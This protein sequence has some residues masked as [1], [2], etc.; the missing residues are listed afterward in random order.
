MKKFAFSAFLL[1]FLCFSFTVS[2]QT[3]S[4]WRGIHRDGIYNETQLSTSWP[5]SGPARMWF[6]E[7]IGDGYGSPVIAN[8]K[9][10]VNG[11]IDSISHVFAFDLKGQL[12]WK[13]ANGKEFTGNGFSNKFAGSRSTPTVVGDL[14]YACSGTGRVACYDANTGK[15]RWGVNVME[16]FN[17]KMNVFGFSESMLIDGDK[18]FCFPGGAQHNAVALNRLTG[19]TIWTSKAM[20]DT[21]S[22]CSP[23]LIKLSSRSVLVNLTTNYILG[24][25]ANTGELLWSQ[26]QE[27]VQY[28]QQ[29]NTPV[30]ADGYIYYVA[31]D[32][33][34]AVKLELSAD[35][36]SMKEVWRN[37][38]VKNN[39]N[40]FIKL[41]DYLYSA[42]RTQKIKCI[43]TA[44]G[45]VTDSL[46]ATKGALIADD[47][48]L[49]LYSDNGEFDLIK[50]TGTKMDIV[51][52]FKI[53]KGTKEHFAHPVIDKGVLYVRH[54]KALMAYDIKGKS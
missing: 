24:L 21:V 14:V 25:D 40:G 38:N 5:E 37:V 31:G 30:F 29:C 11:E 41:G 43:S 7:T 22:Y 20:S 28:K 1:S 49:Y 23:M 42:D 34:G 26:K 32:G 19:E 6:V 46:R 2:S 13:T 10:F 17:G 18:L 15:E 33:N 12:L 50:L 48:M 52:K 9:L 3:I 39:F 44:S 36:R 47:G 51:S 4:Q 27:N 35:G 8:D 16:K 45:S 54:G 53:D